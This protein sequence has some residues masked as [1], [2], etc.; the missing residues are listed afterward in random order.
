MVP[1]QALAAWSGPEGASLVVYRDLP[2][3]GGSASMIAE[4]LA[5]R[6]DHLPGLTIRERRTEAV[7][8]TTAARVEVTA[9]GTGEAL[10]PSGAGT[11]IAP[12]GRSLVPTRQVTIGFVRDDA[13]IFLRWHAP[14]SSYERI[15]ADIRATLDS[16][17]LGTD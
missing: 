5:N 2:V 10:A 11:P 13:T 3:P 4:A 8:G 15:R 16:L 9:P 12:E 7:A 1:G 6:L 14:E 17:R